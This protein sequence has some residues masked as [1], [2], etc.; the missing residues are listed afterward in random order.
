MT[1][2]GS[3]VTDHVETIDLYPTL[4]EASQLLGKDQ[5]MPQCERSTSAEGSSS[6]EAFC[7]E[8][9]SLVGILEGVGNGEGEGEPGGEAFVQADGE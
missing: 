1:S 2:P 7:T 3:V 6:Q 9:K 5:Q 4:V 8:G